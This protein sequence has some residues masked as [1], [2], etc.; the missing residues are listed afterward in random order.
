MPVCGAR[1]ATVS[2]W[3]VTFMKQCPF[4]A[5]AIA[6]EATL[7]KHCKQALPSPRATTPAGGTTVVRKTSGFVWVGGMFVGALLVVGI[8][9]LM[10]FRARPVKSGPETRHSLVIQGIAVAHGVGE[11]KEQCTNPAVVADAWRNIKLVQHGDPQWDEAKQMAQQLEVC[12][13]EI[14]R[15]LSSTVNDLRR[16][17]RQDWALRAQSTLQARVLDAS[18]TLSGQ[19]QEEAVIAASQLDQNVIER[20]TDGLSMQGGSFL[21]GFQKLGG[22]RVVF[23]NGK[24]SWPYELPA[25]AET[26][27]N[28]SVLRGM[29]LGSPLVLE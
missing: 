28:L 4:C 24:H 19:S 12:R 3:E 25:M 8:V 17:Q 6:E 14:E 27:D 1:C 11:K 16:K 26:Q 22:A 23:T 21:E 15:T 2:G 29:G 10:A 9:G 20:V 13:A 18:V 5:G 7:C